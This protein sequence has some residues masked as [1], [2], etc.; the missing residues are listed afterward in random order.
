MGVLPMNAEGGGRDPQS[1][2]RA[3]ATSVLLFLAWCE[4][5]GVHLMNNATGTLCEVHNEFGELDDLIAA[6]GRAQFGAES[7]RRE[8]EPKAADAIDVEIVHETVHE[9]AHA[10]ARETVDAKTVDALAKRA[11]ADLKAFVALPVAALAIPTVES[12][13]A[14]VV[15][16][17]R[18]CP[19]CRGSG[20]VPTVMAGRMIAVECPSCQGAG[21]APKP[22]VR[23]TACSCTARSISPICAVHGA[24]CL[25]PEPSVMD[26]RCPM[27]GRR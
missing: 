10:A 25:C 3:G 23:G 1:L 14:P 15:Y 20:Q 8:N 19:Q 18:P 6:W 17:G 7:P 26:P 21:S 22:A 4:T 27:H 16:A 11:V 2:A 12:P 9:A 5:R 13:K 24:E